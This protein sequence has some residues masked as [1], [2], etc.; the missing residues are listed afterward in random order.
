M[1]TPNELIRNAGQ[2]EI[3]EILRAVI[4]RYQELFPEWEISILS[5]EKDTDKNSQLDRA[6]ALLQSMKEK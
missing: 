2:D 6:I 4:A 3:S 1:Q 5:L